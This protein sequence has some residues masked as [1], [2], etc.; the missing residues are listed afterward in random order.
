MIN[1]WQKT[2][3]KI[4]PG[5]N[6][7][8]AWRIATDINRWPEWHGDLES[9]TME[10]PFVV[11]N[12]FMLKPK[13]RKAVKIIL[14]EIQEGHSF[15]DCTIFPGARMYNTHALE[16]TSEGLRITN[17]TVVR[18]PLKW[19]WVKLVA[20]H[21]TATIEEETEALINLVEQRT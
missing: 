21:V 6:K 17:T 5:V 13:D 11:G 19:L 2:F 20:E 16:E 1:I 9:C 12:H 4:Y 7:E 3:T 8:A 15:T 18:G 10:E 14:T